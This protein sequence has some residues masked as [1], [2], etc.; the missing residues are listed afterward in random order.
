MKNLSKRKIDEVSMSIE[1]ESNFPIQL[2]NSI[3]HNISEV[4]VTSIFVVQQ[5]QDA[6]SIKRS[7]LNQVSAQKNR[8]KKELY[9]VI[10]EGKLKALE[11][12]IATLVQNIDA[13]K[14]ENPSLLLEQKKL[15]LQMANIE[16]ENTLQEMEVEKIIVEKMK[17]AELQREEA[18]ENQ[19]RLL[20]NIGTNIQLMY[21]ANLDPFDHPHCLFSNPNQ[22]P[23]GSVAPS[24]T[25]N[26]GVRIESQA[27]KVNLTNN[28]GQSLTPNYYDFVKREPNDY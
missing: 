22:V 10:L 28:N 13:L 17:Q 16:R 21:E 25:N 14:H 24:G 8:I 26:G 12:E 2:H 4:P 27:G 15:K 20:K 19:L 3:K 7:I 9:V 6:E 18:M 5:E 11:E 23:N 1:N